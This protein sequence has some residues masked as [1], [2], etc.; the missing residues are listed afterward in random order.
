MGLKQGD[1]IKWVSHHDAYEASPMGVKGISPVYRHGIVLETSR[2][3]STAII[4]HCYDCDNVTLVILDVKYDN[5]EVL[6]RN[7]DG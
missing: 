4:A 6:S 2:K 5:V 3:K 7:K 1:L